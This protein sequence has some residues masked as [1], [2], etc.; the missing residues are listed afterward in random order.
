M[1]VS[2][3]VWILTNCEV[4]LKKIDQHE[5]ELHEKSPKNDLDELLKNSNCICNYQK[6]LKFVP[7]I[8][9]SM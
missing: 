5:I 6:I 8:V 4:L 9:G 1:L 2:E 7:P 3:L